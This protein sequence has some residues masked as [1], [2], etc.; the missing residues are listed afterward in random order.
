MGAIPEIVP[1]SDLRARQNQVLA[2]LA[3][4]PIILTQRGRVTAVL[5]S[6]RQWNRLFARLQELEAG[7][8]EAEDARDAAAIE[9]SVASGEERLW[10]WSEV[11][12]MLDALPD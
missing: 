4:G 7:A 9:A 3:H 2:E 1:I 8:E 5:V 12:A 11:E 10:D 6:P